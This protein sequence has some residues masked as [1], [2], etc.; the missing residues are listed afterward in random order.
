MKINE[1][2]NNKPCNLKLGLNDKMSVVFTSFQ[3]FRKSNDFLAYTNMTLYQ[4]A[5]VYNI[6]KKLRLRCQNF[7]NFIPGRE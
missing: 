2:L 3:F 6:L 5:I 4:I 1:C 7:V